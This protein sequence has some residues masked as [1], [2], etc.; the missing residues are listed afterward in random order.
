MKKLTNPLF[1]ALTSA[2]FLGA[3]GAPPEETTGA[4]TLPEPAA[5]AMSK[6]RVPGEVSA[7]WTANCAG[8]AQGG[9]TCSWRCRSTSEWMWATQTVAYGNCN[10]YANNF[11]GRDAYAVCWSSNPHP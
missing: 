1:L 4:S 5:V 9:R 8:W 6:D 3:C 11:C 7:S 10:A 2:M